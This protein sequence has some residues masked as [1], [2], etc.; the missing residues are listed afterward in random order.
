MAVKAREVVDTL[1]LQ[2]DRQYIFTFASIQI[3][4]LSDSKRQS[5]TDK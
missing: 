5:D 3:R 1:Y 4:L 2:S